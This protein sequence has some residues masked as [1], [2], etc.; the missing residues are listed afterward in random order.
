[1]TVATAELQLKV[2]VSHSLQ[3]QEENVVKSGQ[4]DPNAFCLTEK[5]VSF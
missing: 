5:L 3:S 4:C 1:M 2:M